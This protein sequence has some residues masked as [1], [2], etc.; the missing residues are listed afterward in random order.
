MAKRNEITYNSGFQIFVFSDE[1][2]ETLT[3]FKINPADIGLMTR[4][5]EV[6]AFFELEKKFLE[7]ASTPKMMLEV[8]NVIEEKINYLLGTEEHSIFVKPL[9]ATTI[10]PDGRIFAELVMDTVIGVVKPEMEKRA[11]I[12]KERLAKYTAKYN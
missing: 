6:A 7:N 9:T 12:K 8:N 4:C 10:M 3:E 2:G 5:E 11:Q 1:D